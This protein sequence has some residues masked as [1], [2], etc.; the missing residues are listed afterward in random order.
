MKLHTKLILFLSIGLVLVVSIG[1]V[2]QYR[3]TLSRVERLSEDYLSLLSTR[4]SGHALQVHHSVENAVAGSLKR[5]EMDK[6]TQL[7]DQQKGIEGLE[8]FSLFGSLALVTHSS[9]KENWGKAL[10]KNVRAQLEESHEMLFLENDAAIEIYQPQINT[11]DCIR[12]HLDWEEGAIGGVTYFRF[13]KA[14]LLQATA[15]TKATID[16]VSTA[17]L[18][19]AGITLVAILC[20]LMGTMYFLLRKFVQ[21]PLGKFVALLARFDQDDGDLTHRIDIYTKDELGVLAGLFNSFI[22]RLNDVIGRAQVTAASVGDKASSQ[23]A[24][25]EQTTSA[26]HGVAAGAQKNQAN[27]QETRDLMS[28]VDSGM[29][30]AKAIMSTLTGSMD[31]LREEGHEI[32]KIVRTIDD[33]AFQTNLLALNAAV[34]AAHAGDAGAG[35]AV[36]AEE[37]RNLAARASESAKQIDGLIAHTVERIEQNTDLVKQT[38][39]TFSGVS[40][41]CAQA[42]GNLGEIVTLSSEQVREINEINSAL[43]EIEQVTQTN[44]GEAGELSST[45]A[46]FKTQDNGNRTQDDVP[47]LLNETANR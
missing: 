24:T 38:D 4:E 15:E 43:V 46:M 31:E 20:V 12:C 22:A 21:R 13:S 7:I 30:E 29:T 1:L 10:P 36:V 42:A 47:Q 2:L 19:N 9:N 27:A 40:E 6:F 14:A 28:Q 35:F 41:Q 25:V 26:V 39:A 3:G 11:W 18:W 44:A 17:M 33:I 5:G 8:E 34:E 16:N 37:V 32:A 23:A 45:M